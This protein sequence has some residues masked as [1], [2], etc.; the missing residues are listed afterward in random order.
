MRGVGREEASPSTSSS[1]PT[2]S[3]VRP[4]QH[5]LSVRW[6]DPPERLHL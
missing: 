1:S 2:S 4:C 6:Q 3:A 5:W